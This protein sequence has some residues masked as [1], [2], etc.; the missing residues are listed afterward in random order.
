[1]P[2][3]LAIAKDAT[4]PM[5]KIGELAIASGVSAKMVRYYEAIGLIRPAERRPNGYRQYGV[6]DVNRLRFIRMARDS[7]FSLASIREM[8]ALWDDRKRS[9]P[10]TRALALA[11]VVELES[12]VEQI[13]AMIATFR[14]LV[15]RCKRGRRPSRPIVK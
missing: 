10:E 1:M 6:P 9:G 11:K 5:M 12:R 4:R 8:L 15:A 13:D 14:Q 3:A 7:G 2:Y